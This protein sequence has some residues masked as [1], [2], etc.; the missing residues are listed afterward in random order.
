MAGSSEKKQNKPEY[1]E[2]DKIQTKLERRKQAIATRNRLRRITKTKHHTVRTSNRV[3]K[4]G[5]KSFVRNAWLSAAAI[6]MMTITLIVL[7]TTVLATNILGTAISQVEDRVD[8]SIYIK[9]TATE[10]QISEITTRMLALEDVTEVTTTSPDEGNREAIRNMINSNKITNQDV[11]R[12]LYEAPNKMPWV[13]NV[14]LTEIDDTTSLEYF[15][16]NDSSM[17]DML[18]AKDPT[19]KTENRNTVNN[20]AGI[21]N[22]IRTIGLIAAGVFAVIAIMVVFNTIRMSIF[23]RK[24]EIYMMRLVGASRW[25]IVGPFVVEA[26]FYGVISAIV[27]GTVAYFGSFSLRDSVGAVLMDPT[28][29]L[30]KQYWYYY[31]AMLLMVGILIGTI[32]SLLA[33]HKYVKVK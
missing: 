30:L 8:Y 33:T 15:V 23:N 25:F 28:L 22:R 26:T 21:M 7:A 14:K 27:S 32:S 4:Y 10:E 3:L 13:L 17:R 11:I 2:G 31:G 29:G 19:Y 1:S 24:E 5:A 9:Q 18:D 12:S 16:E 6:A 20:I